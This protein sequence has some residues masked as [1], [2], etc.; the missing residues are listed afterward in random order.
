MTSRRKA[1]HLLKSRFKGGFMTVQRRLSRKEKRRVER[2]FDYVTNILS[3]KFSMKSVKPITKTQE[4]LFESYRQG[5]NIA[6]IGTAG[7]GKTMCALYLALTDVIQ[8]EQYE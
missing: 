7:T 2:D 4:N 8:L 5:Y 6:A 1:S 3:Q